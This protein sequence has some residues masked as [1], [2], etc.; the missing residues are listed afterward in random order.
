MGL[1]K[2]GKSFFLLLSCILFLSSAKASGLQAL[3]QNHKDGYPV[4]RIPTVIA[5]GNGKLLAFCEGRRSIMDHGNIDLVM[6]SSTDNGK[7]WGSLQVIW[8][9]GNNT[10]GNPTP[11]FDRV[12][13]EVLVVATL[14]NDQVF[15]LRSKDEGSSW[16]DPVDITGAVKL[17][18]WKWYAT[19]PVHAIQLTHSPYENRLVVPCNHTLAG[20][21]YHVSHTIYSDDHG[22]TWQLGGSVNTEKTDECTVAELA[23]G[24]LILNMRNNDRELPNRKISLSNDGGVTW[25]APQFERTLIEPICQGALLRYSLSPEVLLFSNPK[26][27]KKRKNLTL[28]ISNDEGKTWT[29]PITIFAKK[30]AYSDLVVLGNGDVLC[31]FETGK[32]LPYGGIQTTIIQRADIVG[33]VR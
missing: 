32:I 1:N 27:K 17:P 24:N 23:N 4:F 15:V 22:I 19:G 20:A 21:E 30:A 2:R 18:N 16:E 9:K 13:G 31:L 14:N 29:Q 8:D 28:S 7:T 25:S 33:L 12:T 11:V 5:T 26:H 10:C 6:K 3:F